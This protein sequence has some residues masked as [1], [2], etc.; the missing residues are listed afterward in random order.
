[1]SAGPAQ[2]TPHETET[3]SGTMSIAASRTNKGGR[4]GHSR[5]VL[6][7][8]TLVIGV[9]LILA[10][11]LVALGSGLGLVALPFEMFVL[12][13]EIPLIFHAHMITAALALLLAP[14]VILTRRQ[15]Q[16]HRMLGGVVGAFVVAGGLTALPVAI[17]SHSPA[18]AR[19]GFF[20]QGLVWVGLLAGGIS[21]IRSGD[22]L[23]HARLMVAMFAVTTG[24]VWFRLI[25]GAAILVQAPFVPVYAAAA[26]LGWIVPLCV[27]AAVPD[28]AHRLTQRS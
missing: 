18:L 14:A 11:A 23:R 10:V 17:F 12:A 13:G 21:A 1:M 8:I 26:W 25:T 4:A 9:L 27:V 20:A 22:R 19:A 6:W 3:T 28:F 16:T 2:E 5:T 7:L 15:P 24:A